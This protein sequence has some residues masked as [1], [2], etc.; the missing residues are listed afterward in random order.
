MSLIEKMEDTIK[1]LEAIQTRTSRD[2][3]DL[4]WLKR[5]VERDKELEESI[6]SMIAYRRGGL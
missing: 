2:D 4:M 6:Q 3:Y 1:T 5:A